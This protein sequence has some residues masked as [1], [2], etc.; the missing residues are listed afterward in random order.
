MES[1][2]VYQDCYVM[3]GSA[4]HSPLFDPKPLIETGRRWSRWLGPLI[5]V[6]VL[7]AIII[8][9]TKLNITD[10]ISL[11]REKTT[12]LFWVAFLISYFVGPA[13]DWIIFRRLWNIPISGFVALLRKQVT[14]A[15]LPSY[16]GEVYFYAWARERTELT[17]A[18]FGAIK[19]VAILSAL[20]GNLA[21][22]LMLGAVYI[23]FGDLLR[24]A[25]FGTQVKV[26]AASIGF[27]ALSS[28]VMM[29]FR[30]RLF[31]LPRKELWFVSAV[32]MLRIIANTFFIALLWHLIMPEIEL[33]WWVLVSTIK[34]L[35]TRLPFVPNQEGLFASVAIL[36]IGNDQPLTKL[37]AAI[38]IGTLVLHICFGVILGV[39]DILKTGDRKDA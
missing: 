6:G 23:W 18:P 32:V 35:L 2:F 5:S 4:P 29:I 38:A 17:G 7:A 37:V 8:E 9:I 1:T 39:T 30:S 28:L 25:H 19:D 12:P 11:F 14:N 31:S 13:T 33:G 16:S 15:L 22:L 26:F 20:T 10:M 34:L 3:S 21:T 27:V 24:E 36:L